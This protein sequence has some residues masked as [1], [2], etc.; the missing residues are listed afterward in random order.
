MTLAASR[1]RL[2]QDGRRRLAEARTDLSSSLNDFPAT[3]RSYYELLVPLADA[4]LGSTGWNTVELPFL[5]S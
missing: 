1:H 5:G 3:A 4:A 2:D